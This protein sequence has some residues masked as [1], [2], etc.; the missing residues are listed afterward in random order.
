MEMQGQLHATTGLILEEEF[1]VLTALQS[2]PELCAEEG[3]LS[4]NKL[5]S[6][7]FAD[8]ERAVKIVSGKPEVCAYSVRLIG[9]RWDFVIRSLERLHTISTALSIQ[10]ARLSEIRPTLRGI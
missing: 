1:R 6:E 7:I 4:P 5:K 8:I 10:H 2:G 3:N 9:V